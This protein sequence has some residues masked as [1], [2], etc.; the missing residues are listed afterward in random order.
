[1]S[2]NPFSGWIQ[3]SDYAQSRRLSAL[4]DDVSRLRSSLSYQNATAAAMRS[5]LASLRGSIETRLVRLTAAFD[6]F[7]EL[8]SLRDQLSLVAGPALVRQATRARLVALGTAPAGGGPVLDVVGAPP[9]PGYWLA[10]ALGA[11]GP[12]DDGAADRAAA[13]DQPRTATFLTVAGAASGRADLVARW[14]GDALGTLDPAHPVTRA[15]RAVWI[16]AAE[17]R[18]GDDA[19]AT[20]LERLRAAVAALPAATV[21]EQVAA[22]T[23]HVGGAARPGTSSSRPAEAVTA[24]VRQAVT[25]LAALRTLV[26]RPDEGA[27]AAA[28]GTPGADEAADDAADDAADATIDELVAVLRALVDEGAEEERE[29]MTRVAELEAVVTGKD[30]PGP[31]WNTPVGDL[32]TLLREDA[33]GRHDATGAAARD[34]C[35]PWLL[36]LADTYLADSDLAAPDHVEASAMGV[37]LRARATGT[38]EGLDAALERAR[39]PQRPRTARDTWTTVAAAGGAVLLGVAAAVD[40]SDLRWVY[41]IVAVALA[42]TAVTGIARQLQRSR[43]ETTRAARSVEF[44]ERE[45]ARLQ[46]QVT[47]AARIVEAL[48]ED[49]REHHAHVVAACGRPATGTWVDT[50][51]DPPAV[52]DAPVDA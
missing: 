5:D 1:M 16:A 24:Q 44:V 3:E 32:L 23:T 2:D 11:L 42:I 40:G 41:G 6:A 52:T 15:Q 26:D 46:T 39:T 21:E 25:S 51:A 20:L 35:T 4:T 7:V 28:A 18:L 8:S 45:A 34:A 49:A 47:E 50:P 14:A 37:V 19:R 48:R 9:A 43:E 27:P 12:D 10:D 13:I 29:L 30:A 36:A 31:S 33:L 22:W 38:V 17:G